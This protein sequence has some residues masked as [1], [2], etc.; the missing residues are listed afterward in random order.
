M[1]NYSISLWTEAIRM[2]PD[3]NTYESSI[4]ILLY[5]DQS[6]YRNPVMIKFRKECV[7]IECCE[8][9]LYSSGGVRSIQSS[10]KTEYVWVPDYN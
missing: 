3:P 4:Y 6:K 5:G 7:V 2:L 1:E 10:R 9:N 8:T